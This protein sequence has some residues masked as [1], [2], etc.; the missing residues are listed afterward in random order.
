MMWNKKSESQPRS[1]APTNSYNE[2]QSEDKQPS[3]RFSVDTQY[4]VVENFAAPKG[5]RTLKGLI[6][7][8]IYD[9]H[10][11]WIDDLIN[12]F[13]PKTGVEFNSEHWFSVFDGAMGKITKVWKGKDSEGN[14]ALMGQWN[15]PEWINLALKD[16]PRKVSVEIMLWSKKLSGIA[17]VR[18]PA[19]HDAELKS[20]FSDWSHEQP[21]RQE[22]IDLDAI[23]DNNQHAGNGELGFSVSDNPHSNPV[24]KQEKSMNKGI[25]TGFKSMFSG[26]SDEEK[27]AVKAEL[28]GGQPAQFSAAQMAVIPP[29]VQKTIDELKEF[30]DNAES[31]ARIAAQNA[32]Q[33]KVFSAQADATKWA[34]KAIKAGKFSAAERAKME[35]AYLYF[36]TDPRSA[37]NGGMIAFSTK[38][39]NGE[40]VDRKVSALELFTSAIEGRKGQN[41]E[42]EEA[43]S[44]INPDASQGAANFSEDGLLSDD[45]I[46]SVAGTVH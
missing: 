9:F 44:V 10:E 21:E 16:K 20:A 31:Q 39:P 33:Q 25:L 27:A 17:L 11:S 7:K 30:K 34:D 24:Q 13:D 22:T 1:N 37:E 12:S 43:F 40:V 38:E 18:H 46:N 41:M 42:K 4:E 3:Q 15:E 29:E 36:S 23:V 26:L 6:W 32:A 8:P 14:P 2:T 28:E 35:A 45:F 5:Y 19:V